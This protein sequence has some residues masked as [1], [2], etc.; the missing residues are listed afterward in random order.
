VTA[1]RRYSSLVFAANEHDVLHVREDEVVERLLAKRA[2]RDNVIPS[3]EGV[4]G[5]THAGRK[6]S[7]PHCGQALDA[8]KE[9][10][11]TAGITRQAPVAAP[12]P[13]SIASSQTSRA[14]RRRIGS[15]F[16]ASQSWR[17]FP[18]GYGFRGARPGAQVLRNQCPSVRNGCPSVAGMTAQVFPES[19]PECGRNTHHPVP[20][21]WR[22]PRTASRQC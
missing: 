13:P 22:Q 5:S 6:A 20:H 16:Y 18:E 17:G 7:W 9:G 8:W 11:H 3:A 21:E 19:A 14:A 15:T 10:S 1:A 2:F 4:L 12:C